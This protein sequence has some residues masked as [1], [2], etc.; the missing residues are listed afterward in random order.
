MLQ[1]WIVGLIV[2]IA[3]ACAVW[4]WMP[5]GWRRGAARRLAGATRR[6][7]WVDA[8]RADRLATALA[9]RSGCGACDSCGSCARPGAA[10]AD[11]AGATA[12]RPGRIG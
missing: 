9:Q 3:F 8:E 12:A 11:A 10:A 4:R 6:A 5:A 1:Q 7:G 2:F